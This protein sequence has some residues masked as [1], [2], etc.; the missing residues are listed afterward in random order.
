M[1]SQSRMGRRKFARHASVWLPGL[2]EYDRRDSHRYWQAR[3]HKDPHSLQ[4]GAAGGD[5]F[6]RLEPVPFIA[7]GNMTACG[8]VGYCGHV[9]VIKLFFDMQA[10]VVSNK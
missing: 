10:S 2:R 6:Y 3:V 5:S 8:S 9:F 7:P 4:F 1:E